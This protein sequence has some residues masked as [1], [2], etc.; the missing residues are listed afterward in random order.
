MQLEKT[1]IA[2]RERNFTEI[3]DLTLHVVRRY[4]GSLA[5]AMLFGAIPLTIV[6]FAVVGLLIDLDDGFPFAYVW[7]MSVLI[8]LQAPLASSFA[9]LYLGRVVFN[10]TPKWS[11]IISNVWKA[12]GQLFVAHGLIRGVIAAWAVL[13]L[14]LAAQDDE[15]RALLLVFALSAVAGVSGLVR[16]IR[17]FI[18][19]MIVLEQ[20]PL[21][22]QKPGDITLGMRS[23]S[24][25]TGAAGDLFA[26]GVAQ[27]F[28]GFMLAISIY[29]GFLFLYGRLFNSS[30]QGVLLLCVIYPL[31]L[32]TVTLF[33]TVSRFLQY[34]DTRIRQEGWEV[35]LS[36]R[37]EGER[38]TSRIQST[39][40]E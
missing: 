13:L 10:E 37:S 23:Q 7:S 24:L 28:V 36:L 31:A 5:I 32:W 17:P 4:A 18:T 20:L 3:L 26:R 16:A 1:N 9:T 12:K 39:G 34:L 25:H 21:R 40:L 15:V 6:N 8:Y 38:I 19:E 2:I 33:T 29:G 22:A 14:T 30:T 35:E 27:A 11:E